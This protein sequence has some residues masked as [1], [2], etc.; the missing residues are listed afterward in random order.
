MSGLPLVLLAAGLGSRFEAGAAAGSRRPPKWR[1][2]VGP[3]GESI[4][5][6]NARA[7]AAAGFDHL[8][9]VSRTSLRAELDG[10]L[11]SWPVGLR[12]TVRFQD[13]EPRARAAA[14][15]RVKPLGTAHAVLTAGDCAGPAGGFGVANGDDVYGEDG[16][17]RLARLLRGSD[18]HGLVAYGVARTLLTDRPV[19]RALCRMD[20]RGDLARLAE[21]TVRRDERGHLRWAGGGHEIAL[22]GEEP[23]SMNLWALRSRI[24]DD[25]AAAVDDLLAGPPGGAGP[26]P[27]AEALLPEVIGRRLGRERIRVVVAPGTCLGV[28]HPGDEELLRRHLDPSGDRPRGGG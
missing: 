22:G 8:V 13:E 24:L 28:T 3:D 7:A 18:D 1:V 19:S 27:E 17:R 25:L 15:G 4:L 6:L 16:F 10:E 9:V 11:P 23:V 21:G 20:A 5:G 26:D 14:A 12:V 2:P